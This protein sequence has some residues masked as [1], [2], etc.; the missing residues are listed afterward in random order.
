MRGGRDHRE[1]RARS[2]ARQE[3]VGGGVGCG[4]VG[5]A[6]RLRL[7]RGSDHFF[8]PCGRSEFGMGKCVGGVRGSRHLRYTMPCHTD[9]CSHTMHKLSANT[10]RI[11]FYVQSHPNK[12]KKNNN[13]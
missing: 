10:I 12:L 1:R 2:A 9:L 8:F 11:F 3:L 6:V 13:D 4:R 5:A 7:R